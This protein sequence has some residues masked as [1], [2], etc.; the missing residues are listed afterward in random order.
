[1]E[2]IAQCTTCNKE[3]YR[4]P[5]GNFTAASARAHVK[6]NLDHTVIVGYE[7]KLVGNNLTSNDEVVEVVDVQ[8]LTTMRDLLKSLKVKESDLIVGEFELNPSTGGIWWCYKHPSNTDMLVILNDV[9]D[10]IAPILEDFGFD[11]VGLYQEASFAS[12]ELVPRDVK[13]EA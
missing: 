4:A 12:F 3:V 1:M 2:W 7:V 5:N 13:A 10:A 8:Q 6:E 11:V 9:K